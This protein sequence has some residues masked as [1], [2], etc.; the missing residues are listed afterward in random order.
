MPYRA[1]I[2]PTHMPRL[3]PCISLVDVAPE[4]G[5]S[6][7]RLAGTRL[8]DVYDYEITGQS[9]DQLFGGDRQ[10]YWMTAF[11]HTVHKAIPTQG[12]VRGPHC[13]KDH[14]VQYWLK[15]PLR[16]NTDAVGM[17]LCIDVFLQAAEESAVQ[18]RKALA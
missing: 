6:R 12:V 18:R 10:E 3:L 16:T 11:R 9:I 13:T 5:D 15:L 4:I 1:D 8:R 7:I 14:L 17:V 2:N